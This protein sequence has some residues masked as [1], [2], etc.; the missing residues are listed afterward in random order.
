MFTD[1]ATTITDVTTQPT[2]VVI[3]VAHNTP[4]EFI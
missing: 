3:A 4:Y 2:I 1:V